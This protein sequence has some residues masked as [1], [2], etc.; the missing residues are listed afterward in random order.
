MKTNHAVY[1]TLDRAVVMHNEVCWRSMA[2]FSRLPR[3][4][5][6]ART[7]RQ[8]AQ[9]FAAAARR[10]IRPIMPAGTLMGPCTH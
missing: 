5:L 10:T 3:R 2:G 6:L 1:P 9:H 4:H 7:T 8:P